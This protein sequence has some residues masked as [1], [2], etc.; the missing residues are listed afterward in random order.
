MF[1]ELGPYVVGKDQKVTLNPY[2]WNKI[3]NVLFM[4]QPA[5]IT[6]PTLS[7]LVMKRSHPH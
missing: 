2:A 7:H 1:T 5:G 4:E 3:A 6:C